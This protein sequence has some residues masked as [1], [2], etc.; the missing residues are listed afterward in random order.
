M[1]QVVYDGITFEFITQEQDPKNEPYYRNIEFPS[2]RVYRP[3]TPKNPSA[4][5]LTIDYDSRQDFKS[6]KSDAFKMAISW[7]KSKERKRELIALTLKTT[8][9]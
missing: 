8:A 4:E 5:W 6:S 1:G 9:E 3:N 2:I 7:I